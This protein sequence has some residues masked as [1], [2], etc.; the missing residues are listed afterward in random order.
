MIVNYICDASGRF[1]FWK[2][3]SW[4]RPGR[5][6]V[7][8]RRPEAKVILQ[9]QDWW[10]Q[11]LNQCAYEIAEAIKKTFWGQ[12]WLNEKITKHAFSPNKTICVRPTLKNCLNKT[13]C[14]STLRGHTVN[15]ARPRLKFACLCQKFEVRAFL[16]ENLQ[17]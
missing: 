5:H 12:D 17:I 1:I 6:K 14:L 15:F 8:G 11:R 3:F 2:T 9:G 16:L 4:Y 13:G 10:N 7:R